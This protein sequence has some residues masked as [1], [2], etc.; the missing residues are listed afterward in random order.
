VSNVNV[1]VVY[2]EFDRMA[3]EAVFSS[4]CVR[5]QRKLCQHWRS[6]CTFEYKSAVLLLYHTE[7]FWLFASVHIHY[8]YKILCYLTFLI[9]LR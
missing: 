7:V 2:S 3:K 8:Y 1:L 6:C 5:K 9:I 4:K